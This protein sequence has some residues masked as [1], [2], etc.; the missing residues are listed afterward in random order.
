MEPATAKKRAGRCHPA[1]SFGEDASKGI[2]NIALHNR[3]RKCKIAVQRV[4][5]I[6]TSINMLGDVEVV[7]GNRTKWSAGFQRSWPPMW[8][9]TAA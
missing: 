9:A 4:F 1:L 5:R 3:L 2:N 6:E 7:E 8:S